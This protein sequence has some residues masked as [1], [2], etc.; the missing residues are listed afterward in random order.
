MLGYTYRGS[1]VMNFGNFN[2]FRNRNEILK[3]LQ[4][5][6]NILTVLRRLY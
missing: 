3:H 4:H 6:Q 5:D 1:I 2:G